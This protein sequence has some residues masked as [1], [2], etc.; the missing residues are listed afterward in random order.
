MIPTPRASALRRA[1]RPKIRPVEI[2]P[3]AIE[4]F[5]ERWEF[6]AELMLSSSDCESRSVAD[7]L[8]LEPD[9][10]ERLL[11][12]ASR[13]HRGA[14]IAR[15]TRGCRL[16]D[17]HVPARRT[18]SPLPPPRRGSSSP[19][20]RC[21]HP[22]TTSIVEAPC[23]GSAIK[24]ARS[25]GASVEVWQRRYADGWAHDLDAFE[26]LL[27]PETKLIY[28]NS[29]HNPTGQ[30]MAR[31]VF[32]RL[33]ELAAERSIVALQRRGLSRPRARSA[34]TGCPP[35]AT[36][37]R[38]R[39]LSTPSQRPTGC[40]AFGSAGSPDATARCSRASRI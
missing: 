12:A 28:I 17:M 39:S 19:T 22:A 16:T 4:R 30:Q 38:V 6:Q 3:F 14:R 35:P 27:R 18:C 24:V 1:A 25:T 8:A 15:A 29:P 33:L 26:R 23:Y 13:L 21:S 40:L 31:A 2:D 20:T 5:Y 9:A 10:E 32:D 36:S 37:T 11:R 7:L 34:K